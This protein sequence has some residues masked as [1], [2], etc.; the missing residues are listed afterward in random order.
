[1]RFH[2]MAIFVSDLAEAIH[3]WRDVMRFEL[4]VETVIP[5]G[6]APGSVTYVYP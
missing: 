6:P 3:L 4:A 2:H 1:M 5:D